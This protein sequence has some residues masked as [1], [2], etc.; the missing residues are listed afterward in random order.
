MSYA[1]G[2]PVISMMLVIDEVETALAIGDEVKL[3]VSG[4]NGAYDVSGELVAISLGQKPAPSRC[5]TIYDGVPT[6]C[7]QTDDL[8]NI[9]NAADYFAV[10][11]IMVKTPAE[12]EGDPDTYTKIPVQKI[13][14]VSTSTGT[15]GSGEEDGG[16]NAGNE[17]DTE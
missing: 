17:G 14:S 5:G 2:K 13:K 1:F 11:F 10:D 6:H 8:A 4:P 15:P 7:F 16:E 9:H 3:S 12:T